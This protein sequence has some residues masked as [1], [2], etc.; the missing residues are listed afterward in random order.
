MATNIGNDD[1]SR[2]DNKT[3]SQLLRLKHTKRVLEAL[4]AV[5]ETINAVDARF[6]ATAEQYRKLTRFAINRKDLE[7]YV[8]L[9][10]STGSP[11]ADPSDPSTKMQNMVAAVVESA[12]TMKGGFDGTYWGAY[13]LVT[14]YLT[15]NR[16]REK[17]NK[18]AAADTRMSDLWLGGMGS[19]IND[20]ALT[21]A[22]SMAS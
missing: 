18:T 1:A 3:A 22:L 20:A 4:D 14:E 2:A 11:S 19:K 7:R 17:D 6:E 12:A 10:L 16:G 8:T 13:N 5:R 9:V 21:V 15:W